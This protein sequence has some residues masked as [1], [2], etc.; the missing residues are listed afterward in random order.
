MKITGYA[1]LGIAAA[2]ALGGLGLSAVVQSQEL[3][4]SQV[5]RGRYLTTVG[6]CVACHTD[7]EN[8]GIPFAGGR[9]LETPFGTIYSQNL[10]P[11][12]ETGLGLWTR[13]EFYRALDEGVNRHGEQLYPAFPYP[14]FTNMPRQEIDAI[15]D[16]LRTL[17][18]VT[19]DI[20]ENQL[21]FPLNLRQSVIGWNALFFENTEF[22]SDP[23]QT[24]EW[25]RGRYLVDGPAHCGACH[26]E[27]NAFGADQDGE[28]LRGGVLENWFAPNI[29]GGENGG[30]ADWTVEDIVEFLGHGRSRHTAPMQRMGEVVSF[31]TQHMPQG[32]LEAIAIYLK[33]IDDEARPSGEDA[34]LERVTAGE[35]IFFDNCAACH[36]SDGSGVPYIFAVL[37]GSNKVTAKDPSTLIRIILGGAQAQSTDTAPGPVAMPAFAWK[38]T[39][40]EIADLTTFL[41]QAWSNDASAISA[42][43]V[44]DMR[45]Y[46]EEHE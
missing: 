27:K 20:P 41:R 15:Y 12:D 32:D 5:E 14:Y 7:I 21:P 3:S 43:A 44:A 42:S 18:P 11:D 23:N 10:T 4:H 36:G 24:D 39:D 9:A 22:V 6:N 37:D 30:I 19:M 46:L 8:D 34:N 13:D 17:E 31:S 29:R 26:T 28:Y 45:A 38:L 33:S 40:E 2:G 25:N 1:V 35:S 16:Y